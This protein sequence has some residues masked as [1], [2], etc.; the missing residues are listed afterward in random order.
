MYHN[1]ILVLELQSGNIWLPGYTTHDPKKKIP[2]L[3]TFTCKNIETILYVHDTV[4]IEQ[5][6]ILWQHN[7]YRSIE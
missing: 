7:I 3:F 4:V 5:D 6:R 1:G 2:D